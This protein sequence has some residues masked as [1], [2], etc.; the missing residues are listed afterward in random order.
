MVRARSSAAFGDQVGGRVEDLG[1]AVLGQVV[2][3]E[4]LACV[5]AGPVDLVGAAE[6]HLGHDLER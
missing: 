2:A 3:P 6:R 5:G 4:H 1:P